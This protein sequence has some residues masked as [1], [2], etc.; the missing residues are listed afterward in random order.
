MRRVHQDVVEL[1][2]RQRRGIGRQPVPPPSSRR[3]TRH[4]GRQVESPAGPADRA[5]L[6]APD[7][8]AQLPHVSSRDERQ[9]R[10]GRGPGPLG[11]SSTQASST[12]GSSAA[13][14]PGR[15]SDLAPGSARP[16]PV[17]HHL[18]TGV[19]LTRA[20]PYCG[21]RQARPAK[22]R[23]ATAQAAVQRCGRRAGLRTGR[24]PTAAAN[25][26]R[27]TER[28]GGQGGQVEAAAAGWWRSTSC[29]PT[30]SASSAAT[31]SRNRSGPPPSAR[32]RPCSSEGR[33]AHPPT[34]GRADLRERGQTFGCILHLL[35]VC[36]S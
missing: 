17:D 11:C 14:A 1:D 2:A 12:R 34:V 19:R 25:R 9:V 32:D 30:M 24:A 33:E 35:R 3:R 16:A 28:L 21:S 31:A 13:A 4:P 18:R 20:T 23:P 29:S 10:G 27:G 22:L 6:A 8:L 26:G 15:R 5:A 36:I 7:D